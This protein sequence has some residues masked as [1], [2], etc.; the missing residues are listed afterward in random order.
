MNKNFVAALAFFSITIGLTFL[1]WN[2]AISQA[3]L[4]RTAAPDEIKW[5]L[6]TT[7]GMSMLRTMQDGQVYASSRSW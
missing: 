3:W 6:K 1:W 2:V 7:R 5:S 4:S